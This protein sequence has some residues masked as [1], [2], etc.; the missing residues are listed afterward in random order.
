MHGNV[1]FGA[2]K[3]LPTQGDQGNKKAMPQIAVLR[4]KQKTL[5]DTFF[6]DTLYM[7]ANDLECY[8][9]RMMDTEQLLASNPKMVSGIQRRIAMTAKEN[10]GKKL[11]EEIPR[12][13]TEFG[14]QGKGEHYNLKLFDATPGREAV[15]KV[16]GKWWIRESKTSMM[17]SSSANTAVAV[18]RPSWISIMITLVYPILETASHPIHYIAA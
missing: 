18:S 15:K 16:N 13:K 9:K 5:R 1:V 2:P 3:P 6:V 8:L 10:A 14:K 4:S 11:E 12:I 7:V 17:N